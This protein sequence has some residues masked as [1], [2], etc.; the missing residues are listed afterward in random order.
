ML[1]VDTAD[2]HA[3]PLVFRHLFLRSNALELL[4]TGKA[5]AL[6]LLKTASGVLGLSVLRLHATL[7]CALQKHG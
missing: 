1:Y 5:P 7:T 4:A 6:L 2:P 3:V